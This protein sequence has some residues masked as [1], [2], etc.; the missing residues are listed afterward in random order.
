MEYLSGFFTAY[1]LAERTELESGRAILERLGPVVDA[2]RNDY[3]RFLTERLA[4]SIDILRGA[5]DAQARIDDL[6]I[7]FGATHADTDGTWALQSGGLAYQAGTLH[8]ML[9]SIEAMTAG[10]QA[11]TWT[12][13]QALA[14]LWAGDRDGAEAILDTQTDI[15]VNYF[16]LTVVQVRAEVAVGIGTV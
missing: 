9:N 15:P 5:D 10:N 7:R 1:C 3:F 6:A 2:T 8:L 14:L 12:A 16:W 11:R 4:L 13:A